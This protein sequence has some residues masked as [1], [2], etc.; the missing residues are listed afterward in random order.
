[1]IERPEVTKAIDNYLGTRNIPVG[2]RRQS[3][4]TVANTIF[5]MS[6]YHPDSADAAERFFRQAEAGAESRSHAS[7]RG[8]GTYIGRLVAFP[9]PTGEAFNQLRFVLAQLRVAD[10]WS[11]IAEVPL[12]QPEVDAG[13]LSLAIEQDGSLDRMRRGGP[14]LAHV[15]LTR[16]NGE[17]TMT[18]L[19]RRHE[20][21]SRAYGN[22]LG[23]ARLQHFLAKEAGLRVGELTIVASHAVSE[24][25]S[26]ASLLR[27][28]QSALQSSSPRELEV[29]ARPLGASYADLELSLS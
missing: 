10:E 25:P 26:A 22:F 29:H 17:L 24:G 15:S 5:P 7:S 2:T 14:C 11:D 6:L 19:Y 1:M 23:L 8:W 27:S 18:A 13:G 3:C 20:Y 12:V 16:V 4:H 28:A 9:S 21:E